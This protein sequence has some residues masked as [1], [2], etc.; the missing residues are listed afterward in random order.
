MPKAKSENLKVLQGTNR[1]DRQKNNPKPKPL[2]PANPPR[3]MIPKNAV[4]ARQFWKDYAGKLESLGVAREVDIPAFYALC[5]TFNMIRECEETINREGMIVEGARTGDRVKHP[6]ISILN[7]AR[8]QFRLQCKSFGLDP[9]S[10]EKI[11][12]AVEEDPEDELEQ[13][14]RERRNEKAKF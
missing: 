5:M 13:L 9:D 7:Q 14:F 8:Q 2:F 4:Y 10:R 1:A 11:S 12:V 6:A 3:G